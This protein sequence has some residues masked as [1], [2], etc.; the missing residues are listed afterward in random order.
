V[1]ADQVVVPMFASNL[2]KLEQRL[3]ALT[4]LQPAA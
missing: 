3:D 2:A 1:G 4:A